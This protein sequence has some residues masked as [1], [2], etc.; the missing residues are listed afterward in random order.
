LNRLVRENHVSNGSF[1][2][3][4][5]VEKAEIGFFVGGGKYSVATCDGPLEVS[6]CVGNVALEGTAPFVH[7]HI[8]V[9]DRQGRAYAGHLMPGCVVD[10]TFEVVLHAYEELDLKRELD[11]ATGLFLLDT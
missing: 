10:A 5:N 3:I 11:P 7:A 2:G 4:G 1:I 9:A 8:A 6:S